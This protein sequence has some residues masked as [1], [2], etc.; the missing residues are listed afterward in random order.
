MNGNKISHGG[1][2]NSRNPLS[3][4]TVTKK[5]KMPPPSKKPAP[6]KECRFSKRGN[7][8][9]QNSALSYTK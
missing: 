7:I 6:F 1:P 9:I 8:L 5:V 2:K 4:N 3:V